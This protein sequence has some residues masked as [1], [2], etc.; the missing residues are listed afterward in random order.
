LPK[1]ALLNSDSNNK[2]SVSAIQIGASSK[3]PI[4]VIEKIVV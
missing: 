3:N 2:I 4:T 1:G